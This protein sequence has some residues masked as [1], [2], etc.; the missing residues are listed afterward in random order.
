[1]ITI[2]IARRRA[3][4]KNTRSSRR[5]NLKTLALLDDCFVRISDA[6]IEEQEHALA[7]TDFIK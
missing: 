5:S 7:M 3:I 1:M 4:A 2:E 6:I